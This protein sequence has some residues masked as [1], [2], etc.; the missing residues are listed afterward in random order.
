M[1][2]RY[3]ELEIEIDDAAFQL[4]LAYA[5]VSVDYYHTWFKKGAS[6]GTLNR[7]TEDAVIARIQLTL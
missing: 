5:K 3:D 7:P 2:A 4:G 6:T 1:V